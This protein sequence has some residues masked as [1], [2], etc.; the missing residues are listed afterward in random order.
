MDADIYELNLIY[1]QK[2]REWMLSGQEHKTQYLLGVPMEVAALL[3]RMPIAQLRELAASNILCFSWRIS[4]QLLKD[5]LQEESQHT[6]TETLRWQLLASTAATHPHEN[7][8][9]P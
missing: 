2:V 1:L 6:L 4:P 9:A 8:L 3:K 5:L 7:S